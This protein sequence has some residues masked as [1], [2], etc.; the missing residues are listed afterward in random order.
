MTKNILKQW[1]LKHNPNLSVDK[2]DDV[3]K[4]NLMIYIANLMY[5]SIYHQDLMSEALYKDLKDSKLNNES[6]SL[7]LKLND[8]QYVILNIVNW[9]YGNLSASE[10]SSLVE[11]H[12]VWNETKI[13]GELKFN[14][15]DQYLNTIFKTL[16]E[17]YK[18]APF[19]YWKRI[20]VNDNIFLYDQRNLK[21]SDEVLNELKTIP[22]QKHSVWVELI[23]G[24]LVYS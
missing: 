5:Y 17:L 20:I 8:Q 24:D 22:K 12:S 21:I 19:E 23:N 3:T 18:D 9:F 1:F 10:L 11:K 6:K 2:K 16:F 14:N 4:L 15:I 7:A 13:N